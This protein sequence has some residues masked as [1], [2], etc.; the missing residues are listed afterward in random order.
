MEE[1][2]K[3]T[4]MRIGMGLVDKLLKDASPHLLSDKENVEFEFE[5]ASFTLAIKDLETLL[6]SYCD[7]DIDLSYDAAHDLNALLTVSKL[8]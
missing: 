5:K 4:L 2:R 6:D 1:A 7:D 3:E 8:I